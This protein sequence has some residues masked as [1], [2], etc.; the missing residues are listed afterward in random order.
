MNNEPKTLYKLMVL[1]MLRQVN[2]PLTENQLSEF[3]LSR[4]YT[5]YF[6]LKEVLAE[7]TNASLISVESIHNTSR[8]EI[9]EEGDNTLDFFDKKIPSIIIEDI[10]KY[11]KDNRFKMRNEVANISDYYKS[12][13]G[14][15]VVHYEVR[16]GK[17]KLLSIDL[18]VPDEEQAKLM[19]SNWKDKNS[20]IYSYL[21]KTLMTNP[22]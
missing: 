8:Y 7:L 11:L 5:N 20:E 13:S 19:V 2:F 4:E 16:E 14:D 21:L 1:H 9:T 17:S 6:T 10:E 22:D 15:Y 18:A 3:F 12:T